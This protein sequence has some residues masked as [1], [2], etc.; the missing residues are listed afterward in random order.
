MI[1]R[2]FDVKMTNESN[3]DGHICSK[4]MAIKYYWYRFSI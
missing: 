2:Y 3:I 1:G 4:Q